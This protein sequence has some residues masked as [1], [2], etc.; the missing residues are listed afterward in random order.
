MTAVIAFGLLEESIFHIIAADAEN[1]AAIATA[2]CLASARDNASSRWNGA[3]G[4]SKTLTGLERC[5]H[6]IILR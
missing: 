5:S 2:S 1:G 6:C 3:G 4:V